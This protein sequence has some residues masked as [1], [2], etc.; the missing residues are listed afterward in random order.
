MGDV[1]P[2]AFGIGSAQPAVGPLEIPAEHLDTRG[3]RRFEV[4]E[5]RRLGH[6]PKALLGAGELALAVPRVT[7]EHG[8]ALDA[9]AQQRLQHDLAEEAGDPGE[10]H[11]AGHQCASSSLVSATGPLTPWFDA[12]KTLWGSMAHFTLRFKASAPSE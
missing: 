9:L 12:A 10:E 2:D 11:L 4:P 6:L 7:H 3:P 5:A 8:D 1:P